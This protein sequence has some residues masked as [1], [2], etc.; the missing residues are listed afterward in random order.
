VR[1]A[2]SVAL[3]VA[4][5][6]LA[7]GCRQVPGVARVLNG[8][9][10]DERLRSALPPTGPLRDGRWWVSPDQV[11]VPFQEIRFVDDRGHEK[12][13]DLTGCTALYDR[14]APSLSQRLDCDFGLPPG[15]YTHVGVDFQPPLSVLIDDDVNGLYTDGAGLTRTPP[16]G[17]ATFSPLDVPESGSRIQLAEPLVVDQDP[18]EITVVMSALHTMGVEVAGPT[19]TFVE[20]VGVRLFVTPDPVGA[21][22]FFSAGD[23]AETVS[24]NAGGPT[25]LML[26]YGGAQTPSYTFLIPGD[27]HRACLGANTRMEAFAASPGELDREGQTMGGYLGLDDAG[28]ICFALPKNPAYTEY[29]AIF[30][31]PEVTELG[32]TTT[33]GCEVTDTVPEPVSGPT[34]SSGCP[35]ITPTAEGALRL[36]A[37]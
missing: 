30:R 34:W 7:G 8:A 25:E 21:A 14:A 9:V 12:R 1:A 6:G 20:G 16:P 24:P 13:I 32:G 10:P 26:F 18:V 17:G 3:G 2:A 27:A 28:T 19:A 4:L 22:L 23:S 5:L 33:L 35:E 37:H 11:E 31:M 36:L 29:Q 15:T